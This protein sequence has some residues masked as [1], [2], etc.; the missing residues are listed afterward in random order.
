MNIIEK[1][2]QYCAKENITKAEFAKRAN[3]SLGTLYNIE[4][5]NK[6]PTKRTLMKIRIVLENM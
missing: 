2:Y 6:N 5:G 1:I 3:L 4:Y